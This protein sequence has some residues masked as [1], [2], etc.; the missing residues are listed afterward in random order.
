MIRAEVTEREKERPMSA[1]QIDAFRRHG[2]MNVEHGW[3][4]IERFPALW[5][6]CVY[7]CVLSSPTSTGGCCGSDAGLSRLDR[8]WGPPPHTHTYVNVAQRER[9]SYF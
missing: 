6:M 9:K 4:Y 5:R 2:G 8:K 7:A 1:R 3:V